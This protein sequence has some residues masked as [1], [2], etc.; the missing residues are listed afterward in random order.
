MP[1]VPLNDDAGTHRT[2]GWFM[3]STEA[4]DEHHL[5]Q[6]ATVLVLVAD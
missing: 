6:S 1:V 3:A 5:Q 4:V 2:L